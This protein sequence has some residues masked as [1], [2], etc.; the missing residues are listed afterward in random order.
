MNVVSYFDG[1][2]C[3]QIALDEL[4]IKVDNYFAY[5]IKSH[6]IKL[7]QENYPNT[8]QMGSVLDV[9]FN[10]LPQIDLFIGGSPCQSFSVAGDGT[11]FNGKSG[12]FWEFVKAKE[13]L[14]P[15]HFFLENVK[16]KKEWEQVIT[17]ALGVEP[18]A[19]NSKLFT[20]QNRPRLYWTNIPFDKNII[21]KEVYLKDV[22]ELETTEPLKNGIDRIKIIE[23][24]IVRKY[25]VDIEGLKT[26][27]KDSKNKT[28]REIAT[29]LN[30]KKTTVEHWFRNDK[31]FSIPDPSIWFQL[32][33][34]L[35]ITETKFDKPICEFIEKDNVF[36]M[37]N[38]VYKI[39]GK[40]PTLTA[41]NKKVRVIDDNGNIAILNKT[42]FEK[43]QTMP[44]GYTDCLTENQAMN[45]IGDGWTVDVIKH[46][47][48]NIPQR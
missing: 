38:R 26:L 27:L 28:I 15:K 3:G 17:D 35:N 29:E 9:D 8:K 24:V 30:E 13:F 42:H 1:G 18:I 33:A 40:A 7:T 34:C 48:K 16:M 20:A 45:I 12:L 37:S 36:D 11:G 6:A 44:I 21:D 32:K 25:N 22:L 19:I 14:K 39:N 47:L 46:F 10:K 41:S 2:S 4:N 31:C 43:L 5:E 23:K